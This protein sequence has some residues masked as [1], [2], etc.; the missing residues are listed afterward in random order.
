MTTPKFDIIDLKTDKTIL[1]KVSYDQAD[2]QL[3]KLN[4]NRYMIVAS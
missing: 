2:K 1:S 4:N 3:K